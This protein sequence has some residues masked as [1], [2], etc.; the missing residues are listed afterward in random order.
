MAGMREL[1]SKILSDETIDDADVEIIRHLIKEDGVDLENLRAL[2][3][4]CCEAKQTC[5]AFRRLLL[6]SLKDHILEDGEVF[7][8]EQFYLL[9]AFYAD[10][11]I[12]DE[13]KRLLQE[14]KASVKVVTPEFEAM[15]EQVMAE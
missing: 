15:C 2:V 12:D 9:K 10:G 11:I 7:L 4:M 3:E 1:K 8:S 5:P 6:D 14:I 13:E